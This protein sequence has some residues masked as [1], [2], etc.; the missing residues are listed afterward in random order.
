MLREKKKSVAM[1]SRGLLDFQME[2]VGGQL[3]S[4]GLL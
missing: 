2:I 1:N 3:D 4:Q